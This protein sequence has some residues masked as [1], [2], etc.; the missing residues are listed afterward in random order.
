M[1]L[2]KIRSYSELCKL[3]TF[4]ARYDY[5]RLK[6][7][8]GESTFGFDRYLNQMFYKS[9]G[10][11]SLRDEIIIR[12]EGCDLGVLG[13][14][15]NDLI[16]IHHL[17]PITPEDLEDGKEIL[18]DPENLICTSHRTHMAIHYSDESLLPKPLNVRYPGDTTLWR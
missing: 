12:D 2:L 3:K 10:W 11:L 8:V 1:R 17:N 16:V 18:F 14:E 6:G 9:R 7:V 13:Y 15:I 5:V 4:K